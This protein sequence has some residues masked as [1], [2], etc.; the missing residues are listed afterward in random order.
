M[1]AK[2]F[3]PVLLVSTCYRRGAE[4]CGWF[5]CQEKNVHPFRPVRPPQTGIRQ[6]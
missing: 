5:I 6:R 2:R 1:M 4:H 3:S